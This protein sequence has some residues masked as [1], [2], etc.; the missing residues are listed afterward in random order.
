M[1]WLRVG[2]A[3]GGPMLVSCQSPG[4]HGIHADEIKNYHNYVYCCTFDSWHKLVGLQLMQLNVIYS[5]GL[6]K[7]I[8]SSLT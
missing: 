7:I 8:K 2:G 1:C 5:V 4:V 6:D 3:V